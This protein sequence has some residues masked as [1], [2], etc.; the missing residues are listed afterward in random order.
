VSTLPVATRTLANF[1][2]HV[3]FTSAALPSNVAECD[4][5][6]A[7]L[8]MPDGV[9]DE[10]DPCRLFLGSPPSLSSAAAEPG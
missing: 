1:E 2:R 3:P 4:L 9:D 6:A 5:R 7:F 10:S 8:L